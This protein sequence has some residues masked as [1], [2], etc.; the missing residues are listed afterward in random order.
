VYTASQLPCLA[1]AALN[2]ATAIS[3]LGSPAT[4]SPTKYRLWSSSTKSRYTRSAPPLDAG[5]MFRRGR[6]ARLEKCPRPWGRWGRKRNSRAAA[7]D[8]ARCAPA[9]SVTAATPTDYE[10]HRPEETILYATLKAQ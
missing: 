3:E 7:S 10:R 4:V 1:I 8:A 2:V 9:T 5:C 6:E